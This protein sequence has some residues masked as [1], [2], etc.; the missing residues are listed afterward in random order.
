MR[1]T[2]FALVILAVITAGL[3]Y[4]VGLYT[5][6]KESQVKQLIRQ[7]EEDRLALHVLDAELAYLS[8]PQRLQELAAQPFNLRPVFPDQLIGNIYE[9]PP[10]H[11]VAEAKKLE[12]QR[13]KNAE[14]AQL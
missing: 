10:A 7:I 3:S 1:V 13:D 11:G 14:E 2:R 4:G 6:N 9:L 5:Q 12:P 8:R